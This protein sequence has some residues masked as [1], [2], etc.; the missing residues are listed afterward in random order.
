VADAIALK[1]STR[2]QGVQ[3]WPADAPGARL[4]IFQYPGLACTKFAQDM[5]A[6]PARLATLRATG[7]PEGPH[8][9]INI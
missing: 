9:R 6:A 1:T 4:L 7:R 2:L 5:R 3:A 8:T